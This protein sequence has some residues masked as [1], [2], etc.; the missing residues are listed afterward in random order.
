MVKEFNAQVN[1]LS[2]IILILSSLNVL[3]SHYN[4]FRVQ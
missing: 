2:Y 4:L 3:A 1:K